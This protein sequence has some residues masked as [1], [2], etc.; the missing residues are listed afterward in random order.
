MTR[1]F[2]P[3]TDAGLLAWSAHLGS[4]IAASPEI[5]GVSAETALCEQAGIFTISSEPDIGPSR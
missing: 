2:L 5:Y 4:L 1:G 3:N